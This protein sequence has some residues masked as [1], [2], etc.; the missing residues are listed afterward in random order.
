MSFITTNPNPYIINVPELQGV[1]T[2]ATGTSSVEEAITTFSQYIDSTTNSGLFNTIGTFNSGNV[3]ITSDLYL[4]NA[5]LYVNDSPV[6]VG[7][8]TI[9]G[10]LFTAMTVNNVEVA[11]FVSGRLGVNTPAPA[12]ELHV[13]GSVIVQS[14]NGSVNFMNATGVVTSGM[15]YTNASQ[16]LTITNT[17]GNVTLDAVGGGIYLNTDTDLALDGTNLLAVSAGGA[18]G[19]YLRININGT[20]Y[21]LALLADT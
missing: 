10:N 18:S 7:N 4:S 13:N 21:K 15:K 5:G 8:N 3:V 20:F 14:D 17:S 9:N 1:I 12:A 19:N 6:I 2:S 16:A 11:R